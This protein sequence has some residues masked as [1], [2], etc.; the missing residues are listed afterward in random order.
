[1]RPSKE[2]LGAGAEASAQVEA[3][4]V[5]EREVLLLIERFAHLGE[6]IEAPPVGVVAFR[7]EDGVV[8]LRLAGL[9]GGADG[10]AE[11]VLWGDTIEP[12]GRSSQGG[13]DDDG[14]TVC[15]SRNLQ[16][17]G[18]ELGHGL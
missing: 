3:G 13:S 17:A 16:V 12:E 11:G 7:R 4:L 5:D 6:E 8:N 1:M 18:K 9:A 10:S 14:Y 2:S 15:D